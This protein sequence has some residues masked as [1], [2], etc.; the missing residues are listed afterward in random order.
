M[1]S[2]NLRINPDLQVSEWPAP[3]PREDW[4][5]RWLAHPR[6][7][8]LFDL[9]GT[10]LDTA[11]DLG[12]VAN[13][14]REKAGLAPMDISELRPY[15]SKGARGLIQKALGVEWDDPRFESLRDDFLSLYERDISRHTQFMPGLTEVVAALESAQMP[16]GIVTNKYERFTWP[17]VEALGLRSRLAVCVG[18]DTTPHAKPHPA[19]LRHAIAQL[20][21]PA[22]AVV[23]V[24]DDYRDIVSGFHAG[25]FTVA[26]AF[27][28]CSSER[29]VSDWGADATAQEGIDL[30]PLLSGPH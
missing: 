26:A 2:P 11:A 30:L 12:G 8:V 6:R 21:L 13:A 18:G 23:Y 14:L 22:E 7:A 20:G 3:T 27:G 17:L 15:A 19:P 16:W 25:C 24:G 28:F 4:R 1:S 10:L 29:P 9:D 5:K